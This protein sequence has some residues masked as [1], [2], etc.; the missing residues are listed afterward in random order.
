MKRN[1]A[2]HDESRQIQQIDAGARFRFS[3]HKKVSCFTE[4][5][6]LL[7]L[8]LSPYDVLRLRRATGLSSQQVLDQYIIEEFAEDSIFP[9]YYLTMVDDGRASCVFVTHSGCSIYNDRPGACR[10]YPMGR[11]V[12]FSCQGKPIEH[13]VLVQETHCQGF[14]EP[15]DNTVASFC[16]SQKMEEYNFFNDAMARLLQHPYLTR[17]KRPDQKLVKLFSLALYNIDSFRQQVNQGLF[18]EL[19]IPDTILNSDEQL[20]LFVINHL[21]DQLSSSLKK[22]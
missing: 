1:D 13:F 5:C 3:C 18:P 7:D 4:C 8:S 21:C 10:A 20:L 9:S 22:C 2:L 12:S 15:A 14:L 17:G 6:R 11:A 19:S 16:G